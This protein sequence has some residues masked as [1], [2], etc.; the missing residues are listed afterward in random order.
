MYA[1]GLPGTDY[2]L[3]T[4]DQTRTLC[5][6]AVSLIIIDRPATTS[7]LHL[8]SEQPS[9]SLCRQCA[10]LTGKKTRISARKNP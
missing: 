5:G 7:V 10:Q 2:H 4:D 6:L 9:G 8:T 1:K 3:L